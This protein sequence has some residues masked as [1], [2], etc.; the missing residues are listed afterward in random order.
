[1]SMIPTLYTPRLCLR[2]FTLADAPRVQELAGHEWVA[3]STLNVPHPYPEG[4]AEMWID[5]HEGSAGIGRQWNFAITLAGTRTPGREQDVT[6]TGHIIG[7]ISVNLRKAPAEKSAELGYWIGVQYWNKGFATEAAHAAINFA[8]GRLGYDEIVARH[9]ASNPASGRVM[10][11]LGM[12]L[13]PTFSGVQLKED[14]L[15]DVVGYSLL[16]E[17]W[18]VKGSWRRRAT[19]ANVQCVT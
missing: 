18:R 11:K 6:D 8:F 9:F 10:Q 7:T 4:A 15:L 16:R 17:E 14:A 1:M 5:G 13:D 2:A 19:F 3:K 12:T